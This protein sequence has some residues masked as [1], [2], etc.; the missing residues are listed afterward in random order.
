MLITYK[1]AVFTS[2]GWR[3][4]NITA[5]ADQLSPGMA[6]V[7]RVVSIDGEDPRYGMSRTGAR[8]Q[9]YNGA[10]V[11]QREIGARKRLTTCRIGA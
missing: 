5:E 9:E 1:S 8:R 2:A 10:G 3:A 11:A 6:R 7:T 4:V